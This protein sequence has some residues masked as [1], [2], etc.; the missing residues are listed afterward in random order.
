MFLLRF[1]LISRF[2]AGSIAF[3]CKP[4]AS[5]ASG[6]ISEPIGR[7]RAMFLVNIPH[8]IAWTLMYF[9]TT[10][11]EIFIANVLIGIGV[12]LMEAPILTYIGEIW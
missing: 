9:S 3:F 1:C 4:F 10:V 2:V 5:A 8:V 6:W 7:K 11:W 12:G